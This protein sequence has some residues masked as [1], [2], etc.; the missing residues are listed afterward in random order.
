MAKVFGGITYRV[1]IQ[2][3]TKGPCAAKTIKSGLASA[4]RLFQKHAVPPRL[5]FGAGSG[6]FA[7]KHRPRIQTWS[8]RFRPTP[9]RSTRVSMPRWLRVRMGTK[10]DRKRKGGQLIHPAQRISSRDEPT[11]CS[12]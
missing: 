6:C 1:A 10:A 11:E 7:S 4:G 12:L 2:S 8:W 5:L 9:G 3:E